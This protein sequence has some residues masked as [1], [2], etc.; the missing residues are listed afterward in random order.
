MRALLRR[1]G[2]F[3]A[4]CAL[5]GDSGPD[6]ARFR[7]RALLSQDP[8]ERQKLLDETKKLVAEA[9][10]TLSDAEKRTLLLEQTKKAAADAA[11]HVKVGA[12]CPGPANAHPPTASQPPPPHRA[13]T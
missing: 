4:V 11:T 9:K 10:V 7:G 12:L 6:F 1:R 8:A 13:P 5:P 3:R 2:A